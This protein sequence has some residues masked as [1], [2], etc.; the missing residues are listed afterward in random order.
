MYCDLPALGRDS[1]YSTISPS[2]H[3][4]TAPTSSRAHGTH[5]TTGH[6]SRPEPYSHRLTHRSA[7]RP[8]RPSDS[9]L[10]S[11]HRLH[12]LLG[13]LPYQER[14]RFTKEGT[15]WTGGQITP[16]GRKTSQI[17][18]GE[19]RQTEGYLG[20]IPCI[21]ESLYPRKKGIYL[22]SFRY[23]HILRL[24]SKNTLTG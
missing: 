9:P 4:C 21:K 6:M 19:L 18:G 8:V 3:I 10:H 20:K 22:Y 11:I 2:L 7:G 5:T 15:T 1:T 16:I 24:F 23:A 17:A 14:T 13:M 12:C